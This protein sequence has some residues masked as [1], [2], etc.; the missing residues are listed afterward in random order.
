M[1]A[2]I[3][4]SFFH[5]IAHAQ[6]PV[7]T[8]EAYQQEHEQNE[9]EPDLM[10]M[11]ARYYVNNALYYVDKGDYA[12]ALPALEK[13]LLTSPDNIKLKEALQKLNDELCKDQQFKLAD[14]VEQIAKERDPESDI[15]CEHSSISP[16][17]T[18]V[19]RFNV[20]VA[21]RFNYDDNVAY[22]EENFATGE[23]DYSHVFLA[24]VFYDR[25][26]GSGWRFFAQGHFLQSLYHQFDQFNQTRLS[27]VAAIGKTGE[28]IGW[29]LPVEV[30]QDWLDGSTYRT[31]LVTR[32]GLLVQFSDGFFSH[33]YGRI[34]SD[35]YKNFPYVE[36]DRSGDVYGGGVK[37]VAQASERIKLHSYLEYN[38]YNTDGE[39]WQRDD[40]VA[41]VL[42]EF[43]FSENWKAGLALRYQ[44]DDYDNARP[45]FADRQKDTSKEVY[46][47]LTYRLSDMWIFRAQ[48]SKVNHESNI[49]I[50]DYDRN[51]YSFTVIWEL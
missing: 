9:I 30:T 36:E 13:A 45:I 38:R 29:R 51:V 48:Y 17:V 28:K 11:L 10:H 46:L 14:E 31:S 26:F 42:G 12:R 24:D 19:S 8:V 23:A 47:S 50:F 44:K 21:Y 1:L 32:P 18:T 15:A 5:C 25:P 43:F 27:A 22:P 41:F 34:Q 2:G 33:F 40:I 35:D 3:C 6:S 20:D 16:E 4:L 49:A 39:Y 7:D 37:I